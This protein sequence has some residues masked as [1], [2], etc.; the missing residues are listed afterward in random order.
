M[1][2]PLPRLFYQQDTVLLAQQLLGKLL[3]HESAEGTTVGQIVETEAY[4]H[5][6]DP[7]AHTFRG[8]SARNKAMF[9]PGGHAYIYFTYGMHYCFNVVAEKPGEGVL[10]RAL[11]PIKG[12]ELMQQR[13]QQIDI[14]NLCS[15][16]GKLVQAMGITKQLYG[17]DLT[18]PP[19]YLT[20]DQVQIEPAEIVTTTRVGI[21]LAAELPLRFYLKNNVFISRK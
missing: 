9:G 20:T 4:L 7:A 10:I 18:T 8:E 12:V 2:L 21:K 17:H 6:D 13:R 15:G 1:Y 19:L 3:V 16:P 11:E 14:K 5:P